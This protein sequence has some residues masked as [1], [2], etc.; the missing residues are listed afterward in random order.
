[1]PVFMLCAERHFSGEHKCNAVGSK[2]K[3]GQNCSHMVNKCINC[4]GH[5]IG[6]TNCCF[7]QQEAIK[8]VREE[9]WT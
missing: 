6:K 4:K 1:M 5:H 8:Q 2:A 7:K 3:A 9:G